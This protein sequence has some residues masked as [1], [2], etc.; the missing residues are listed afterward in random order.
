MFL[1]ERPFVEQRV[2]PVFR[3]LR[4]GDDDR[5]RDT[6]TK[7]L[8][9][10]AEKESARYPS[11][12]PAISEWQAA[13]ASKLDT[14]RTSGPQKIKASIQGMINSETTLKT[15]QTFLP[16]P[17]T[18]ETL[19]AAYTCRTSIRDHYEKH[20]CPTGCPINDFRSKTNF[21]SLTRLVPA[22]SCSFRLQPKPG[23][24]NDCADAECV[25]G[26]RFVSQRNV[27]ETKQGADAVAPFPTWGTIKARISRKKADGE[28]LAHAASL[29]Q[30]AC[31]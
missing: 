16:F 20:P 26:T 18:H 9:R 15:S 23:K 21:K 8:H 7:A 27:V 1:G 6:Q 29:V 30:S 11:R 3:G 19:M 24:R 22:E 14:F 28:K 4:R 31:T 5:V 25:P 13:E 10:N 17:P 12:H 2:G